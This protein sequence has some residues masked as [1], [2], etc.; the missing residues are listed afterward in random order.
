MEY[1]IKDLRVKKNKNILEAIKSYS[2]KQTK[3]T[4]SYSQDGITKIRFTL[5][6]ETTKN[7]LTK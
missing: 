7:E 5:T 4:S 2:L 1:K 6:L 3:K